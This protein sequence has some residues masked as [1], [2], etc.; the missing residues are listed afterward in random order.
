MACTTH[1]SNRVPIR[2]SAFSRSSTLTL[3]R[4]RASP[5]S[6]SHAPCD[7][8]IVDGTNVLCMAQSGAA[9]ASRCAQPSTLHAG[10]SPSRA[11]ADSF[12][13]WLRFIHQA[14][15]PGQAAIIVFD[16]SSA[17]G[18]SLGTSVRQQ[19]IP[20]YLEKRHEKSDRRAG[21]GSQASR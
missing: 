8:L 2:Q 7:F 14:A 13:A 12:R 5:P 6:A 18:S 3:T 9:A 15:A 19:A 16:R 1:Q 10:V 21:E 4:C 20:A 17:E 11:H